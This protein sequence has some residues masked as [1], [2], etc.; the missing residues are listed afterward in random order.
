MWSCF[1]ALIVS[2]WIFLYWHHTG[3]GHGGHL[4]HSITSTHQSAL[5]GMQA[6]TAFL[7]WLVMIFAMMLPSTAPM[8]ATYM[9]IAEAAHDKDMTVVS[10]WV[11]IAGYVAAWLLFSIVATVLQLWLLA[12]AL[13]DAQEAVT[14]PFLAAGVLV[15]A[16]IYQFLPIKHACLNKCASPMP[17]FLGNWSDRTSGVFRIG[18][19]QGAYCVG[20]CWA[21]M[22]VMFVTGLMNLFWMA[23]I[24]LVMILEKTVAEPKP[25]SYGSG[26]LLL[27]CRCGGDY[28]T[29][30]FVSGGVRMAAIE[31]WFT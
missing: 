11:L 7:M 19:V 16:G 6:V 5:S 26:A 17:F 30:G 13:L 31:P 10:P 22:L 29:W 20:C 9:D 8:V 2:A 12:Q 24:G 1:G 18:F 25:W 21:L 4:G 3:G 23:V 28:F 15:G 27:I 14:H